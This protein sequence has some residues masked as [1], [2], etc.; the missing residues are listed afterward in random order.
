ME[1]QREYPGSDAACR[2]NAGI[3]AVESNLTINFQ[4]C[5]RELQIYCPDAPER[6]DPDP[7][8]QR[9]LAFSFCVH[10]KCT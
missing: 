1:Q 6:P 10:G 7:D 4:Y 3:G 8:E 9:R 5:V 2:C